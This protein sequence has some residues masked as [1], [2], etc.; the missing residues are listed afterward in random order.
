MKNLKKNLA[1][2]VAFALAGLVATP[3]S[4]TAANVGTYSADC[5]ALAGERNFYYAGTGDTVTLNLTNCVYFEKYDE[6]DVLVDDGESSSSM[7]VDPGYR[8]NF[9]ADGGGAFTAEVGFIMPATVPEGELLISQDLV[10]PASPKEFTVGPAT[11]DD[12]HFLDGL[13]DCAIQ[14]NG[15]NKH[16]Y[17]TQRIKVSVAG[18]YTFRNVG[19]NP[20]GGYM[21]EGAFHPFEDTMLAL[22]SSFNPNSSDDNVIGCNDDLNDLFEYDNE[23]FYE[24]LGDGIKMEGH[25]PYFTANL[26]P[27]YYTI[28]LTTWGEVTA[29]QW[30]AGN[31]DGETFTPGSASAA[32]QMWG[33]AGGLELAAPE[34]LANTGGTISVLPI[35]IA[36]LLMA[37]GSV[38]LVTNRMRKQK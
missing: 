30:R 34:V 1:A 18:E 5:I 29:A 25:Q 10:I 3:I 13:E 17:T 24:D 16:I 11:E 8:Y 19:T 32:F 27:G 38:F 36:S 6:F 21:T 22:Y 2:V 14:N 15:A 37:A 12:E 28:V 26:T 31:V 23:R 4:A 7:L 20:I 9:I 35:G 33:P